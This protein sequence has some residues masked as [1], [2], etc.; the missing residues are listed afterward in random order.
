MILGEDNMKTKLNLICT[1]IFLAVFGS[2]I[3]SFYWGVDDFI[4]GWNA[5]Y[6]EYDVKWLELRAS[7]NLNFTDSVY[8]KKAEI[9]MPVI[10]KSMLVKTQKIQTVNYLDILK[11]ISVLLA[12]PC[13]VFILISF[14]GFIR[15]INRSTP[16]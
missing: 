13:L 9:W 16:I 5:G 3:N 4:D 8:D 1:F 11:N 15:N 10:H 12:F 2:V 14:V 6:E 7:D